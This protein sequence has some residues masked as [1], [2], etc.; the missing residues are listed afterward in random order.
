M[1][2]L[3]QQY[4]AQAEQAATA[5]AGGDA[6]GPEA[7]AELSVFAR[8]AVS[9]DGAA[10]EMRK[11]RQA[12]RKAW[13]HCHP[14]PLVTLTNT[15]A[16]TITDER[17][18]PRQSWAWQVLRVSVVS[19]SSGGATAAALFRDSAGADGAYQLQAFA[20]SAGSFLGVW[21]PKGMFLLP[22]QQMVWT[23]TGGGITVNGEAIE[24]ALDWLP[25]Y[26]M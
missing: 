9:L 22:G 4:A 14:I 25:T 21:E 20:G 24:I 16:G 15:G 26:L 19:N 17:W 13:E 10:A 3:S 6:G 12:A 18:Q 8:L 2:L 11:Q 23:S 7:G 1:Q 5:A